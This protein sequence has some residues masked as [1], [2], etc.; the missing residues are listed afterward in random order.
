MKQFIDLCASAI[1]RNV[2]VQS[3]ARVLG[4]INGTRRGIAT[5]GHY[6]VPKPFNEPNVSNS[7]AGTTG[8]RPL[9]RAQ[10]DY[11]KGSPERQ[12]LVKA[13][14]DLRA[15]LPVQVPTR[16]GLAISKPQ[17]NAQ[18]VS[19]SMPSEHGS[20]FAQY[21]DATESDVSAAIESALS[22]KSAWQDMP[23]TDRAAIFLRAA[24]LVSGKYRYELMAATML[25]QGKNCMAG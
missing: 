4:L 22:A 17:T 21:A 1:P 25:G 8:N 16:A 24:E 14:I 6:V 11:V 2:Q 9:R 23:F 18:L 7:L 13:L 5:G 3:P 15:R 10:F 12:K 20:I 19:M